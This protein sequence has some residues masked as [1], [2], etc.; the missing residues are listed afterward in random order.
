LEDNNT[1]LLNI[2]NNS[3][4]TLYD[5][6]FGYENFS[7]ADIS[8][9]TAY[10]TVNVW[11]GNISDGSMRNVTT[12]LKDQWGNEIFN[13]TTDRD[14]FIPTQ[15]IRIYKQTASNINQ[16]NLTLNATDPSEGTQE[17]NRSVN[18]MKGAL[19]WQTYI[20]VDSDSD[21][22]NNGEEEFIY[23]TDPTNNDTDRDGLTDGMELGLISPHHNST[24]MS[25]FQA[26]EDWT[27]VTEL[28]LP[29]TDGDG[30][31]DG[32]E[33]ENK[34]GIVDAGETDPNNPDT[35]GDGVY[36][37]YEQLWNVDTDGD[38]FINSL[39]TDSDGDGLFDG[40]EDANRNGRVDIGEFNPLLV[41]SDFDGTNDDDVDKFTELQLTSI[42]GPGNYILFV[43][44]ISHPSN[45]T[46]KNAT[47]LNETLVVGLI[48]TNV[49]IKLCDA[50]GNQIS[51]FLIN[52][53]SEGT[54]SL[55]DDN[56]I[57]TFLVQKFDYWTNTSNAILNDTDG[58]SLND[59]LE[60][61]YMSRTQINCTSEDIDE[62]G[63]NATNDT[64]S[65]GDGISDYVEF[66]SMQGQRDN[67]ENLY[68][69][70]SNNQIP[71]DYEAVTENYHV[72]FQ[73]VSGPG[74]YMRLEIN[75]YT[76]EFELL[77]RAIETG[78]LESNKNVSSYTKDTTISYP[79]IF[80]DMNATYEV[81]EEFVKE[82]ISVETKPNDLNGN[83]MLIKYK[84]YY[85]TD[86]ID[87]YLNDTKMSD[88]F[89]TAY[90][91]EFRNSSNN[92]IWHITPPIVY[93]SNGNW[94]RCTISYTPGPMGADLTFIVPYNFINGTNTTYPIG[95]DPGISFS[96]IFSTNADW[97]SN[98]D[99]GERDTRQMKWGDINDD[100]WFD[101]VVAVSSG[102]NKIYFNDHGIL[103]ET[104]GWESSESES[105]QCIAVGD[106]D[107]DSDEDVVV[108]NWNQENR[109]YWNNNGVLET[110]GTTSL[111]SDSRQ[112][113]SI[114]LYDYDNDG[115]L[116][117][118][119][120]D[121]QEGVRVYCNFGSRCFV[122]TWT[123]PD[124]DGT[125]CVK[126]GDVNGDSFADLGVANSGP[127]NLDKVYL[128]IPYA[129]GRTIRDQPFWTSTK[130]FYSRSLDF[131]DFDEDGDNDLVV[132]HIDGFRIYENL[133]DG[134]AELCFMEGQEVSECKI[135]EIKWVDIDLD[136]HLDI[137][138]CTESP[139]HPNG[140]VQNYYN[141]KTS[142]HHF[143]LSYTL[144]SKDSRTIAW[145][146]Y[147]N[148]GDMDYVEGYDGS[149]DKLWNNQIVENAE[150]K[151]ALNIHL[152][153]RVLEADTDHVKISWSP[154][155]EGHTYII[156]R[157]MQPDTHSMVR[158]AILQDCTSCV[159]D[160]SNVEPYTTYYYQVSGAAVEGSSAGAQRSNIVKVRTSVYQKFIADFTF[161]VFDQSYSTDSPEV[162][163]SYFDYRDWFIKAKDS[164]DSIAFSGSNSQTPYCMGPQIDFSWSFVS[165][166]M[167]GTIV[168]TTA[169]IEKPHL[170][171]DEIPEKIEVTLEINHYQT[172]IFEA[173]S[174][175]VTIYFK[176]IY[177]YL[178]RY[179][180]DEDGW[181]DLDEIVCYHTD[182]MKVDTDGD[183]WWDNN[184]YM[185][186]V[187][188]T[189][190]KLDDSNEIDADDEVYIIIDDVR[191]PYY[192]YDDQ[193]SN[194][195]TRYAWDINC[196]DDTRY[197]NIV[198]ATRS[199]NGEGLKNG[200]SF[201]FKASVYEADTNWD[202]EWDDNPIESDWFIL[203]IDS[204]SD[205]KS[206]RIYEANEG[207]AWSA[208]YKFRFEI[209]TI[210]FADPDPRNKHGDSDED[211]IDDEQEAKLAMNP[212]YY[213]IDLVDGIQR[214]YGYAS[215][216][217]KDLFVEVDHMEDHSMEDQAK[218]M[219]CTKFREAG[220]HDEKKNGA[221]INDDPIWLH[222]DRGGMGGGG[223]LGFSKNSFNDALESQLYQ[224]N[225]PDA[226]SSNKGFTQERKGIFHYSIFANKKSSGSTATG[227]GEYADDL[228]VIY[229]GNLDDSC[230]QTKAFMH[231]LGHNLMGTHDDPAH[232]YYNPEATHLKDTSPDYDGRDH[233][234]D[235]NCALVRGHYDDPPFTYCSKCWPC[236][237][238]DWCF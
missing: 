31:S 57:L 71:Y 198:V 195:A 196:W 186:N 82:I 226:I 99:P 155:V 36:D 132:G 143:V 26:D 101:L 93:D 56:A 152:Y 106:L 126:W 108:G 105:T 116:D 228:F 238:L 153:A 66:N 85:D 170:L 41:D 205:G 44:G 76:F 215:P 68:I 157:S 90:E 149:Q 2:S 14:G 179:D 147:D 188:L 225:C 122:N 177:I 204:F 140:I 18:L 112:T 12:L 145:C 6:Y 75:C 156:F 123:S 86:E 49:T 136:E 91:V 160:D 131:G 96:D 50:Y 164:M 222:I 17:V 220:T 43:N 47:G 206:E 169:D 135:R 42:S 37:G 214:Y 173:D 130:A 223:S 227:Y 23:F 197:P 8:N 127:S 183:G 137:S 194:G 192:D 125:M 213:G 24:N 190:V 167:D 29:D 158:I 63:F 180:S 134:L 189:K 78:K 95:I 219:V 202:E 218:Y 100:G 54:I 80:S 33:D 231:E 221:W 46:Y 53:T 103:S 67:P 28:L 199:V 171:L 161:T 35:D 191:Y 19:L 58:D 61:I 102:K 142:D 45:G 104:P 72:Y 79:S 144:D 166:M 115:D 98:V 150:Q 174:K 73:N 148:D 32:I 234:T 5:T 165:Y 216:M 87:M 39:D 38:G 92:E 200:Q 119:I 4:P 51:G 30:L 110:S 117:I 70:A 182:P 212:E 94:T 111:G 141:E 109:I 154:L 124:N 120:G 208:I 229:D 10:R 52:A 89:T 60:F 15:V 233:C 210:R 172:D 81:K 133:G 84:I 65:D 83:D 159:Y 107:G 88:S 64:D 181:S 184:N 163:V 74:S 34:N 21:G 7:V 207:G 232:S 128:N 129:D 201:R 3:Y 168:S 69:M 237:K 9:I 27:S 176:S 178:D 1:Y 114:D 236:I 139:S 97:E 187:I 230:E 22:I 209:E 138:Y 13:G 203:Y 235:S 77:E 193:G 211:G 25:R 162:Y 62:D 175:H 40:T 146:D 20:T 185:V 55:S 48:L 151:A 121:Y 118:A 217:Q 113:K 59:L 16:T 11:I 224:G